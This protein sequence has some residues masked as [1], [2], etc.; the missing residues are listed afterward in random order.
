MGIDPAFFKLIYS[1]EN[2]FILEIKSTNVPRAFKYHV[3]FRFIDD[4]LCSLNN[5]EDFENSH[6]NLSECS[7]I[8]AGTQRN[9]YYRSGLRY[10]CFVY[11]LFN[12]CGNFKFHIVASF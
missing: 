10:D 11:K 9:I 1:Y 2:K 12:K 3:T 5:G 6:L 7:R 8:K 4:D